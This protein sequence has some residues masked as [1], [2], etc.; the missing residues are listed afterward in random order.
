MGSSTVLIQHSLCPLRHRKEERLLRK[1]ILNKLADIEKTENVRIL[2]AV[3]SGTGF[4]TSE[5]I[6]AIIM[7]ENRAMPG[8]E[9]E[10]ILR[11][12]SVLFK[13]EY[14]DLSLC[15]FNHEQHAP[16]ACPYK[17]ENRTVKRQP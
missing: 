1:T 17:T 4:F 15:S 13:S 10:M 11:Q 5:K 2:L 3:E 7:P 9:K 12:F 14:K 6:N 16:L 8:K